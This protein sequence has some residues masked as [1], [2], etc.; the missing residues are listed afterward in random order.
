M[1]VTG[2]NL[3]FCCVCTSGDDTSGLSHATS[4]LNFLK[5]VE[6]QH[7]VHIHFVTNISSALDMFAR[8]TKYDRLIL[9]NT[10]CNPE[11]DFLKRALAC[12]HAFVTGIIPQPHI[13]WD[14]VKAAALDRQEDIRFAGLTYNVD[15]EKAGDVVGDYVTVDETT[16]QAVV[17]HRAVI[18]KILQSHGSEVVGEPQ[19][20]FYS[21]R[22]R[23]GKFLTA[24]QNFCHMWGGKIHGDVTTPINIVAPMAFM[25]TV[26][27][28]SVL[29]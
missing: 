12:K 15:L 22:V 20:D 6:G 8:E 23:D 7:Q 11:P 26:G 4:L 17:I 29:R 13:D 3:L 5:F 21:S 16:L 19:H 10:R 25:G 1:S 18:A 2:L 28:R 9:C 27:A 14:K 24:D